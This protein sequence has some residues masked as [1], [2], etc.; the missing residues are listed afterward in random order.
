MAG[1]GGIPL[2]PAERSGIKKLFEQ[3]HIRKLATMLR[4]RDEDARVEV[5]DA[6]YWVAAVHLDGCAGRLSWEGKNDLERYSC[7][8]V[9]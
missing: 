8:L 7:H 3:D 4:S 1:R 2:E 9:T 6:A 5:L